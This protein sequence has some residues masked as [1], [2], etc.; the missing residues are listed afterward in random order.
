MAA[1]LATPEPY[2]TRRATETVNKIA[3]AEVEIPPL[4][5][6]EIGGGVAPANDRVDDPAVISGA[7]DEGDG[8]AK[9]EPEAGN[10]ASTETGYEYYGGA[11]G[12]VAEWTT[13]EGYI[14]DDPDAE[15]TRV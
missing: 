3:S 1:S 15:S 11:L 9:A 14:Y 4:P 12:N 8:S 13:E 10:E 6:A 2:A 7:V 5:V